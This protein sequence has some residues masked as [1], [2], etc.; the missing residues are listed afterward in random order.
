M[1]LLNLNS[2]APRDKFWFKE[3][4]Y[5]SCPYLLLQCLFC[6]GQVLTDFRARHTCILMS[7]SPSDFT[8]GSFPS[9]TWSHH[10]ISQ[11]SQD[12]KEVWNKQ[13][14]VLLPSQVV[15]RGKRQPHIQNLHCEKEYVSLSLTSRPQTQDNSMWPGPGVW[16]L[17]GSA[18][19]PP[20][21][22]YVP[23]DQILSTLSSSKLPFYFLQNKN[24]NYLCPRIAE[25]ELGL[26]HEQ[27]LVNIPK[28]MLG[29]RVA[30][31]P[32]QDQNS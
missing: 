11:P 2:K 14:L 6:Q 32:W 10:I 16:T 1:Y 8:R 23:L 22:N 4:E 25:M 9:V 29:K 27:H 5:S 3:K 19:V 18:L 7:M 30:M 12:S 31:W 26:M 13:K 20:H 21:E 24:N 28:K 15:T 17:E